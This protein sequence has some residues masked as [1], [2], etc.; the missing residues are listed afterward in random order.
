MVVWHSHC[1]FSYPSITLISLWL[2][3]GSLKTDLGLSSPK[4]VPEAHWHFV[5][6]LDCT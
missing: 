2:G 4:S 3:V 1:D 6:K 5:K